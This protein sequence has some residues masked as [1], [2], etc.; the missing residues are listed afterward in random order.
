MPW[1]I[2]TNT[3]SVYIMHTYKKQTGFFK[4]KNTVHVTFKCCSNQEQ[5]NETHNVLKRL[6]CFPHDWVC[7]II[8]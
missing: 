4:I 6:W 3:F 5:S 2:I 1:Q 8:T 7:D